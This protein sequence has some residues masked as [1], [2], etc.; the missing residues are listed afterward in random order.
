MAPVVVVVVLLVPSSCCWMN[1]ARKDTMSEA[2]MRRDVKSEL[3]MM[4]RHFL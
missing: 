4:T 3:R 1:L 2:N